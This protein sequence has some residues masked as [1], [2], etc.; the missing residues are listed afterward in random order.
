M[1]WPLTGFESDTLSHGKGPGAVI[2]DGFA[3]LTGLAKIINYDR[4]WLG[5]LC[6]PRQ[7]QPFN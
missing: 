6:I 1:N 7:K 4:V 2:K 5:F 3:L